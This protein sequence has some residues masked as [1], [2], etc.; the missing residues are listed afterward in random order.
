MDEPDRSPRQ[1]SDPAG[2]PEPLDDPDLLD[3]L[4][5]PDD[6]TRHP[7]VVVPLSEADP[8]ALSAAQRPPHVDDILA[9]QAVADRG[10]DGL[11]KAP[12]GEAG[13][14]GGAVELPSTANPF[15]TQQALDAAAKAAQGPAAGDEPEKGL[16]RRM[17]DQVVD[18]ATQAAD[19]T[20]TRAAEQH[21][22]APLKGD[23]LGDKALDAGGQGVGQA[24]ARGLSLSTRGV[25]DRV[26]R[27]APAQG[28]LDRAQGS[29]LG[30][31]A[32]ESAWRGFRAGGGG[33]GRGGTQD[34]S[35]QN[36]SEQNK[37]AGGSGKGSGS[38][39]GKLRVLMTAAL[40]VLALPLVIILLLAMILGIGVTSDD[41]QVQ[42]EEASDRKV[43]E[44]F[45]EGWQKILKNAA[46]RAAEGGAEDYAKPP[47]TI[48]AGIAK[49]QTDFARYSPY[50]NIDRDPGRKASEV[51]SGEG[52]GGAVEVGNTSGAGPGPVRGVE[53]PGSTAAVRGS[54]GHS[55]PPAGDL[56]HQLGWFLYALRK[57]E[58]NG[59][60]KARAGT[61]E[62]D[63]CGA[64]QVISSTWNKFGGY[65]TACE[66]PPSVQ[67]RWATTNI[68]A[69]WKTYRKWQQ[70]AA[71][72][73]YPVWANSPRMW[74]ECPAACSFNPTV[75]EYVDDVM[76][77]MRDAARKYPPRG[78]GAQPASF[79]A[80]ADGTMGRPAT[81]RAE[82]GPPA[83]G[84]D[85]ADMGAAEGTGLYADGCAVGNPT[86]GIG[87]KDN[88]G[89]GPYL[90]SPAAAA[91]MRMDGLDPQN[92]C[93]S[94]LF[95]ARELTKTA[96]RVHAD[97]ESP[98]WKPNGS[99]K[100]QENARKYWGKIIEVAGIFVD[101]SADPD[102]PCTVPPPD[103]PDK[104]WSISFKII[105]VW[106]CEATRLQDLYLVTGGRYKGK[107]FAYSVET[108][109]ATA[110][111]TLVNEAMSVSYGAGKWKTKGC[112]DDKDKRQGIFPMT[113]KEAK[114][115]GVRD[116]CDVDENIAGAAKLV[117]SVERIEPKKRPQDLGVFQPMV[118]GWAKLGI[119]MG[120]DLRLFSTI[121]P[122]TEF[123]TSE[124][125]TQVMT[126]FLTAIAPHAKDFADLEDPPSREKVYSEWEPKLSDLAAANGLTDP[127]SDR[128]CVIGSWAP[129]F[130]TALA[131]IAT[132]LA[133]SDSANGDNLNGLA[134]YY[135]GR[136]DA[137]EAT[138][139]VVGQD[140]LVIPRLALRPLTAIGAPIAPDATKAWSWLG[141]T[142]GVT[143]P[144]EQR[145]VE[146]AWFFGGVIPPF[147]SAGKPIGSLAEGSEAGS[148]PGATQV[149]VGPDGC[150]KKAPKNTLR[151]GAA[152][153][154]VHK[155][156]VDSVAKARTPEAAKAIK[157]ALTHLGLPYCMCDP[158]RNWENY[159][160]CSSFV[161][162]AYRSA[163]PN[164]YRGNAPT[165]HTLRAV[166]WMRKIPLSQAKPGDL[167]EPNDGHVAMQLADGYKV[168]T[169]TSK[170][171]SRVE[172]DYG[173][174]TWV[175]WFD[176]SK[177]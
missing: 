155:L 14:M 3:D 96:E 19:A 36:K 171:V 93:D 52:G 175:G 152:E 135:Q 48:L 33:T 85:P 88:Q 43:A 71:A 141:S 120:T 40:P 156:C 110:V 126:G 118:G 108:D 123:T 139:P 47:W 157:W 173:K 20:V 56:S 154:G 84:M 153:I 98:E 114:A 121:G 42:P 142:E 138:P 87:G 9:A 143:I 169:N 168:H 170:D 39:H 107:E 160:D 133:A 4:E 24:L 27:S 112:D 30:K 116:R 119:A 62:S 113:K 77:K 109:R 76:S 32:P 115:A 49:T 127:S 12:Y 101:R 17:A 134:N 129:G 8:R 70:V 83:T 162:R 21:L 131:Q 50:D 57:H 35:K 137:N 136:E 172:R 176:R 105:S 81:S 22:G 161:S 5:P 46:D 73:F 59:D 38:S 149:E 60:Y 13:L 2:A 11:G 69:K 68:L 7:P 158:Q 146:Y 79:R 89:S 6:P 104:P 75:W 166:P 16:T 150:P 106:R 44:Y 147:D 151:Q 67:D 165:T 148:A 66:A 63:A 80:G 82:A 117:L 54:G 125:C 145:A 122:G 90:I 10:V 163:V 64:Y 37:K 174:A 100:D 94:S 51:P 86:P 97:P 41:E 65:Q 28:F 55:T 25:S 130:N 111:K 177:V 34:K 61:S 15:A 92:P 140:T 91:Q 103:D 132:G 53:G 18:E 31:L 23:T 29:R 164:L 58:S 102:R 128:A 26:K 99:A 72:H 45:P 1:P 167:V 124:E 78:G 95:V 74:D 144:L 159:A